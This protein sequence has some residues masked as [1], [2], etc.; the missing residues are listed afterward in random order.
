MK[1]IAMLC[2]VLLVSC[3]GTVEISTKIQGP[4]DWSWTQ[5]IK[6]EADAAV[7]AAKQMFDGEMIIDPNEKTARITIKS[8]QSA[9]NVATKE[10]EILKGILGEAL[11]AALAAAK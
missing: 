11:V 2:A 6:G 3:A 7:E 9:D 10:S 8:G 1:Y 5:T 4:N